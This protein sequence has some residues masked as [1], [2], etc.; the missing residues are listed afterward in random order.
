MTVRPVVKRNLLANFIGV[1]WSGFLVLAL[2]PVYVRFLGPEAYGLVG[3]QLL[4]QTIF[5][6]LDFGLGTTVNRELA[7]LTTNDL[8]AGH[9]RTVVRTAETFY[10]M[11]ATIVAVALFV[12]APFLATQ[13]FKPR[14]L[15]PDVIAT[16]LRFLALATALR[17]PYALYSSALYGLQQ[18]VL[19]N[20]VLCIVTT[21]RAA[22]TLVIVTLIARDV[23]LVFAWEMIAALLLTS[24]AALAL[25][26]VM[27]PS[28]RRA[29]FDRSVLAE[30]WRFTAGVGI[31]G[32]LAAV[33]TQI[34][35]I[36]VSLLPLSVFGYYTM[37][38]TLAI[39][40][41]A[42]VS[43]V[44]LTIFPRFSQLVAQQDE[45]GLGL[46]Y[47]RA[48]ETLG[49]ILLPV[50]A[51]IILFSREIILL[52]TGDATAAGTSQTI[53]ALLV[54]GATLNAL[55]TVPY[56]LQLAN[57]WT[58]PAVITNAVGVVVLI[59]AIII[60]TERYGAVGAASCW[61]GFH[62]GSFLFGTVITHARYLR[63]HR[64]RWLWKGVIVPALIATAVCAAGRALISHGSRMVLLSQIGITA[65][66]ALLATTL[67][68]AVVREWIAEQWPR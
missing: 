51:V 60:A 37:G 32:I 33:T 3:F 68:A 65:A 38:T 62:L 13:W 46:A 47:H 61:F 18:H 2:V 34:D 19:L 8:T 66:V 53:V 12:A 58:T 21:V 35:K 15:S 52:W 14:A 28:E 67:S 7:R 63:G 11:I 45:H 25:H 43:P 40:V 59:P 6:L 57:A 26:R 16:A 56:M 1:G 54:G 55:M 39:M 5:A 31:V 27:P 36:A 22:G 64:M 10:W 24:G 50:A 41:L 49:A 9:S 20:G 29:R 17:F 44:S 48:A 23:R 42:I 30:S 4:L